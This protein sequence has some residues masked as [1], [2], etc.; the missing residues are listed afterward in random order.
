MI[1][2]E[3]VRYK[4]SIAALS[5]LQLNASGRTTIRVPDRTDQVT[6]VYSSG[7]KHT[8]GVG[9]ALEEMQRTGV[10]FSLQW[11][12]VLTFDGTFRAHTVSVRGPTDL[13]SPGDGK[14]DFCTNFQNCV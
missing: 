12:V 8:E 6:L 5:E 4:V 10:P 2:R 1:A 11:M 3:L 7:G 14:D 13:V 9:F